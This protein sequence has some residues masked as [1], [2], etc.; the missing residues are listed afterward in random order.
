VLEN[1]Y[2]EKQSLKN[3]IQEEEKKILRKLSSELR[4][5]INKIKT[6]T[7][8]LGKLDFL[9]A[10]IDFIKKFKYCKP[11]ISKEKFEVKDLVFLPISKKREY[12]PL[13]FKIPKGVTILVGTN[14]GGKST[15]L[16]TL[17]LTEFML[18]YGLLIPAKTATIP[19][20]DDIFFVNEDM[21]SDSLSSFAINVKRLKEGLE[22]NKDTLLLIDEFAKGTNPIE[23]NALAKSVTEWI[24]ENK[25][26]DFTIFATHFTGPVNK[27]YNLL[28]VGKIKENFTRI[29]ESIDH[30][31]SK[32]EGI[33]PMEAL[34]ISEFIGLDK[35]IIQDAKESVKN[36]IN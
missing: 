6:S 13:S 24:Y 17:G 25:K 26:E 7:N 35:K 3:S 28:K 27:K 8:Q 1:L 29:E 5:K 19:L 23:G 30:S 14:M 20:L 2:Y 22:R 31:I 33:F 9:L 4:K 36:D 12:Q 16:K 34:K 10:K 32:Y 18:K 15:L 11:V 21:E